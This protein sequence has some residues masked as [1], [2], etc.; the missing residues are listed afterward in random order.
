MLP[1]SY[2]LKGKIDASIAVKI[3]KK[4]I[5]KDQSD[6]IQ[7]FKI[8]FE[9]KSGMSNGTYAKGL[10]TNTELKECMLYTLMM[11]ERLS[12]EVLQHRRELLV[13]D[14][15]ERV[16]VTS[17]LIPCSVKCLNRTILKR[18]KETR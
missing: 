3:H 18:S 1:Y 15:R 6:S 16:E 5:N 7:E 13:L 8:P 4:N 17:E 9:L 11:S 2:G 12:R 10:R 14:G